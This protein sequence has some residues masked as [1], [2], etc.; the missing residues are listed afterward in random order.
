MNYQQLRIVISNQQ[1]I[2][3]FSVTMHTNWCLISRNRR[4]TSY[5]PRGAK[6]GLLLMLFQLPGGGMFSTNNPFIFSFEN[7]KITT[8]GPLYMESVT[9]LFF[10]KG[11]YSCFSQRTLKN[12]KNTSKHN[13]FYRRCREASEFDLYNSTISTREFQHGHATTHKSQCHLALAAMHLANAYESTLAIQPCLATFGGTNMW[14][15]Q[16][17]VLVLG[18][19]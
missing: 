1:I 11:L 15:P 5:S 12:Q 3:P 14:K 17:Q 18:L 19:I 7:V 4:V 6:S 8:S 13:S 2:I 9:L 10:L 16:M